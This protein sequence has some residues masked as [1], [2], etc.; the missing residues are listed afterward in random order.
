M[1]DTFIIA[2]IG[3]YYRFVSHTHKLASRGCVSETLLL[4]NREKVYTDK[5]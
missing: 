3:G 4:E 1:E 2:F 5:V